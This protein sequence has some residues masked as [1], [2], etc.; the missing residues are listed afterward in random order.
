MFEYVIDGNR[1]VD[2]ETLCREFERAVGADVGSFGS[3]LHSFDDRLFG[4]FEL[5]R[6]CKI[7]WRNSAS[8]RQAL[9]S[10]QLLKLCATYEEEMR[11]KGNW[12]DDSMAEGRAW[13]E[14]TTRTAAAGERTLFDEI[15]EL[16]KTVSTRSAERAGIKIELR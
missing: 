4:G 15:L 5:R 1:I 16:L 3:T 10:K 6:P 7:Q 8:T 9:D 11:S 12:F 13:V 2:L 14:S